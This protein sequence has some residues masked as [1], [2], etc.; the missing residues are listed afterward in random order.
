MKKRA[1]DIPYDRT[2]RST[3]HTM[4]CY[5]SASQDP[6]L[7]WLLVTE[8]DAIALAKGVVLGRMRLQ[9]EELL[10]WELTTRVS[11]KRKTA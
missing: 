2:K 7:F 9:I 10:N 1:I 11:E 4:R 5:E 8:E 6:P 3:H